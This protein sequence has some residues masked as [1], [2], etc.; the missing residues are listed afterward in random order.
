MHQP[1]LTDRPSFAQ[2]DAYRDVLARGYA[3]GR[4][5]DAEFEARV[6]RMDRCETVEGLERQVADLPRG[7]LPRPEGARAAG[8]RTSRAQ[9]P[10]TRMEEPRARRTRRWVGLFAVAAAVGA[11]G[12]ALAAGGAP[13]QEGSGDGQPA[14]EAIAADAEA[15][16]AIDRSSVLWA[17]EA[18]GEQSAEA[19]LLSLSPGY[20]YAEVPAAGSRYDALYLREGGAPERSPGGTFEPGTRGSLVF[21][22]RMLDPELIAAMVEAAPEVYERTAGVS[23]A[24]PEGVHVR[25][26]PAES[27]YAGVDPALP[28][29]EVR[30]SADDYGEG[31]G[32]VVWSADGSALVEVGR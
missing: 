7:E 26:H 20:L 16:S 17:F 18:L 21:E 8:L 29:V 28:L 15:E 10:R 3:E 24:R 12:G 32:D 25:M 1:R 5:D 19:S 11:L 6:G 14:S 22:T 4:L 31:G 30:M 27:A 9:D 13:S 2:R 23:G